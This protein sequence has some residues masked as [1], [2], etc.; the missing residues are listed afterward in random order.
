MKEW[1]V[2]VSAATVGLFLLFAKT[3]FQH[4]SNPF[5]FAVLFGWLFVVILLSAFAI[6]RHAEALAERL[7]EPLGTL[8]L[9]E[10]REPRLGGS[11]NG[12]P[13]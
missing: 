4:L 5:W 11:S 12:S 1:P 2:L 6:V 8:V 10:R 9:D 7:G 3:W 13:A